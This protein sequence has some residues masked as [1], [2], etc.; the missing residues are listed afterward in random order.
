MC[1]VSRGRD[2]NDRSSTAGRDAGRS[3]AY[4]VVSSGGV[5]ASDGIPER[6]SKPPLHAFSDDR[7]A[8]DTMATYGP[9]K[10]ECDRIA[11]VAESVASGRNGSAFDPGREGETTT[12]TGR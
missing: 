4:V 10:T 5:Y 7:T 12:R 11:T 2:K 6:E 8:D 9:R 1:A 3:V